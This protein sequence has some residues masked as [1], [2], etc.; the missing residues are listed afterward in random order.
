MKYVRYLFSSS[1]C[2]VNKSVCLYFYLKPGRRMVYDLCTLN[3]NFQILAETTTTSD[4][5]TSDMSSL[6][7]VTSDMS[8]LTTTRTNT[9]HTTVGMT[10]SGKSSHGE[11]SI[12]TKSSSSEMLT[13]KSSAVVKAT[14][15]VSNLFTHTI[16]STLKT[17]TKNDNSNKDTSEDNTTTVVISV[18]V[19]LVAL[20]IILVVVYR[21]YKRY[22]PFTNKGS[23]CVELKTVNKYNNNNDSTVH[24]SMYSVK[25]DSVCNTKFTI[26]SSNGNLRSVT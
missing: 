25:Q 20:T 18:V 8:S 13:T 16:S 19:S 12:S 5:V 6:D 1:L 21:L 11:V 7:A 4:A 15:T 2:E 24:T 22:L 14:A 10:T 23:S 3:M 9:N 17:K 26:N